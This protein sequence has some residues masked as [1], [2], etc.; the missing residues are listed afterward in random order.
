MSLKTTKFDAAEYLDGEEAIA[1]YLNDALESDQPEELIHALGTVA[2]A[3]GMTEIARAAGVGRA[4][5]Y[6]SLGEGAHPEFETV[7]K[8]IR[9]LGLKLKVAACKGIFAAD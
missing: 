9:S 6:K 7:M 1:A 2:R 3:K 5:L 8:V 4:S